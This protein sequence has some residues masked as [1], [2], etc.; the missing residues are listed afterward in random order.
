M[1]F[2]LD[3]EHLDLAD[4]A[5]DFLSASA[6]PA[7]ARSALDEG[8]GVRPGRAELIKSGYA[9]ITIPESA[10]GGGGTVLQLAV[11][12]EQAGRV[13]AGPSLV[14]FARAAVLLENDP[15]RLA[16]LADGSLAVAVIDDHD[17]VLDAIGADTFL[18]LRDGTLVCGPGRVTARRPV[19]ATRG[20]GDVT[21]G[22]TT[23]LV[24]DARP[25]WAKAERVGRTILAAEGLGAA[26]RL[27]G[28]GVGYAKERHTFGRPIGSYQA[29][30]HMLVDVYVAVEQLRSLVWWAAWA[31]DRAPGELPLAAAA[32]KAAAA[33]TLELAAETVIQVH[34]GIGYTWEHDAHLYWR[35]AKTDR[36]LLGDD[37]AAFDE[38]A[39]LAMGEAAR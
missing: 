22:E 33:T 36:F 5:R 19:D 9:T 4:G 7:A 13:L 26:S 38:V 24:R 37:V 28:M 14:N 21:L 27:L 25:R 31:A 2:D 6:S 12:A 34:G 11:V 23:D 20:L 18:T 17:P 3:Q 15:D 32:A 8:A 30:K 29:V 1:N 10:G 16:G 35:R 39:R